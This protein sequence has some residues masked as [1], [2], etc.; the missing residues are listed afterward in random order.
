MVFYLKSFQVKTIN[1]SSLFMSSSIVVSTL[2][3]IVIFHESVG[4]IKFLGIG[5]ILAAI[6]FLNYKNAA[7]ERNHYFG[8]IAGIL[9]GVCYI[10]DKQIVLQVG[11]LVYMFWVFFL[12]GVWGFLFSP[13]LVMSTLQ[14]TERNNYLLIV[15]SGITY[16]IFNILCFSAYIFG[17]EVG[18]IDAIN[19]TQTFFIILVEYFIFRNTLSVK[20]KI[21]SAVIAYIGVI[22]LAIQ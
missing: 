3:G 2:L 9:F 20:R 16:F 17:G 13:R 1:I 8:L 7:L 19:N 5:T 4:Y 22:L 14:K 12:A 11:P 10:F 18:K 21:W 15:F 6:I